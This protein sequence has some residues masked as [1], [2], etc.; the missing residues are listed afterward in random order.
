[1]N[2]KPIIDGVMRI[3]HHI[4]RPKERELKEMIYTVS[5]LTVALGL[6]GYIIW[7]IVSTIFKFVS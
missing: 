2:L 3:Y 4:Q 5:M 6:T 1:M 7:Y